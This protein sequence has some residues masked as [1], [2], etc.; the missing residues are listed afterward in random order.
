MAV[1]ENLRNG[2]GSNTQFTFTFPILNNSD[3]KVSIN[4]VVIDP[5]TYSIQN[6]NSV[7]FSPISPATTEQETSGAPKSGTN[8]V[9]LFRQTD[10]TN[11]QATYFSGSAIRAGDLNDNNKQVRHLVQEIEDN[12]LSRY[13]TNV[14]MGDINFNGNKITNLSDQ[15][16]SSSDPDAADANE[17]ASHGWV[18]KFFHDVEAETIE[19]SEVWTPSDQKVSTT[20]AT[21]NR[22]DEKVAAALTTK[23]ESADGIL[24]TDNTP[25]PGD[26]TIGISPGSVDLDRIKAA[27]IVDI[28]ESNTD[29][30]LTNGG[31]STAWEDDTKIATIGALKRR[32]ENF[33]QPTTPTLPPGQYFKKGQFHFAAENDNTLSVWDGSSWVPVVAGVKDFLKQTRIIWV[34]A[35]NGSDNN[36]GHRVVDPMKTI[37]AAVASAD[38]GD[39]VFVQPGVYREICPIDLGNKKNVSVIGLSMR[40]VFVHPTPATENNDMFRCGSGTFLFNMTW[41]GLKVSGASRNSSGVLTSATWS[42]DP[43]ATHGLPNGQNW[44]VR[45]STDNGVDATGVKFTKSPYV[46]NVTAFADSRINNHTLAEFTADPSVGGFFDATDIKDQTTSPPSPAAYAG[47]IN[48]APTAGAVFVDG[49]APH[50]ASPL[51]SIVTNAYTFITLDGPGCLVTN[52]GYAQLVSTF[53]TFCHYHCKTLNGGMA[54]LSNCVTDFGRFGLIADGKGPELFTANST[55]AGSVGDTVITVG[56]SSAGFRNQ[57]SNAK[58]GDHMIARVTYPDTTTEEFGIA[59]VTENNAKTIRTVTLSTGLTKAIGVGTQFQFFLR[60]IVTS[61]S[62]VFE[63][64]GS[65]TDYSSH[66]D[67]GGTPD[68]AKQ[69]V[70]LNNG[71]VYYSS[72][73][74]NGLFKVGDALEVDTD[75]A[76]IE[77]DGTVKY[78]GTNLAA[79][80]TTDTTNAS[81]ISSG[82]LDDARL[83]AATNT[84]TFAY[85]RSLTI[86]AGGRVTAATAGTPLSDLRYTVEAHTGSEVNTH[87]KLKVTDLANSTSKTIQLVAGTGSRFEVANSGA[88]NS[89]LTIS[90]PTSSEAQVFTNATPP[91]LN[92]TDGSMW[93]DSTTGESYIYYTDADSSQWVQFAPQQRGTGNGTVTA[94][95]TGTGLTGGTINNSGTLSLADTAVTPGSYGD[96]KK[97]VTITVDQQGRLTSASE[98]DV[99]LDAS[100]V[101]SGTFD[102]ARIPTMTNAKLPILDIS[103][104]PAL[105]AAKTTSG[106]FHVDRIPDLTGTGSVAKT[107]LRN[108]QGDASPTL[109]TNLNVNGHDIISSSN[110]NIN[111]NPNGTGEV[112]SKNGQGFTWGRSTFVYQLLPPDSGS[113]WTLKLPTSVG[114]ANQY[115]KTNGSDQLSWDTETT[116]DLTGADNSGDF[117]IRLAGSNST[118]D[119]V[120]IKA[121][122]GISL[123]NSAGETTIAATVETTPTGCLQYYAGIGA[124]P[125][126]WLECNGQVVNNSAHPALRTAIG[127]QYTSHRDTVAFPVFDSANQFVLPDLRG[128]FIRG[129]DA[130]SSG[131]VDPDAPRTQGEAQTEEFKQHNHGGAT[132]SHSHSETA[133][134][135]GTHFVQGGA[136]G[137]TVGIGGRGSSTGGQSASIS[138]DGGA[139]TRPRNISFKVIIKT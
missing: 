120:T 1:T 27:D 20:Q 105:T 99:D 22:I 52:G 3:V 12:S 106:T 49:N 54:N 46:Q 78:N 133:V 38:D 53:G 89:E 85:P 91:T 41:A 121:G 79:S 132:G 83:P 93:W 33:V 37:K 14:I 100:D 28:S 81:N 139:E 72:T 75:G 56:Q 130:R 126:G 58:P 84:G 66:P 74:H 112:V 10:S 125:S 19:S 5:A 73:D 77:L 94:V 51:R 115:L 113:S 4:N 32:Y 137:I 104:V 67:N 122:S 92:V 25:N 24:V 21:D 90:S 136:N 101:T 96:A 76:I 97:S 123:T 39:M 103:K 45:M 35:A 16:T 6:N 8:N 40:S 64:A 23:V 102:L 43:D 15:Y 62:H 109:G 9:R 48:S 71:K 57:A 70:E 129:L 42:E 116:Y 108:L 119:D 65:G 34:D 98:Q 131:A 69:I 26:I 61:G 2:D 68:K 36:D 60:S 18:R 30:I 44:Y 80:A 11:P 107:Y 50:S 82:T 31:N 17:A 138:N 29:N 88:D 86:S 124:I 87:A 128:E 110:G 118:N 95:A 117:R 63:F 134:N 47:D 7:V 13:G 135:T 55:A 111:L 114:S 127:L 59:S